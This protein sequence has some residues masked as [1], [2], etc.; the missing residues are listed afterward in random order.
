MSKP[1]IVLLAVLLSE[2]LSSGAQTSATSIDSL[3]ALLRYSVADTSRVNLLLALSRAYVPESSESLSNPDTALVLVRQAY[4]LSR[5]LHYPKGQGSS[6]L[7]GARALQEKGE[8]VQSRKYARQAITI[9][10]QAHDLKRAAQAYQ[11]LGYGYSDLEEEL[12]QKIRYFE[13]SLALLQKAGAR[14]AQADALFE[15]GKFYSNQQ[16]YPRCLLYCQQ[17]LA[18]YHTVGNPKLYNIYHEI[19]S[20]YT[21]LGNY[22]AGLKYEHLAAKSA[23]QSQASS[24][25]LSEVYNGI[26]NIYFFLKEPEKA[27]SYYRKAVAWAQKYQMSPQYGKNDGNYV[28]FRAAS[29]VNILVTQGKAKKA[30]SFLTAIAQEYPAVTTRDQALLS[31][32]LLYLHTVLK[33]YAPARIEYNK[34]MAL[35]KQDVSYAN[36]PFVYKSIVSFLLATKQYTQARIYLKKEE[37]YYKSNK[38]AKAMADN[39]L[40][41]FKLDSAQANYPSAIAHYQEYTA[42]KDSLFTDTESKQ[43]ATLDVQYRTQQ[44]DQNIQLLSKEKLLQQNAL[45]QAQTTRNGMFIGSVM[46][47]ALLGLVL[48][49]YRI[50]QRSN[51][52]LEAKQIEIDEKNK[53]LEILLT[54]KEW[55]LQEIHHRV[56]N[57]LQIIISLLQSQS[58]YLLDEA[59]INA[60]VQ[61]QHRVQAMALIHQKLYRSENLT[62]IYMPTYIAEVVDHLSEFFDPDARVTFQFYLPPLDLDVA[63][64]VPL[65]LIINEAV[66]NALKYAFPATYPATCQQSTVKVSLVRENAGNYLLVVADNGVGMPSD[67]DLRQSKSMGA[68][69]MRGLSKQLGGALQVDSNEGVTISVPFK[70]RIHPRH[71]TAA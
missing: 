66:T 65:G 68:N 3:I 44:K 49:R 42:I 2:A 33:Q 60:I 58:Q 52:L 56:K 12:P 34:L 26:G 7:V 22:P 36:Q 59:A 41:W 50:K 43:I 35:I 27:L 16:D 63:Q 24:I 39:Q 38:I 46:L 71:A 30:L 32:F 48:N 13:Q 62:Q 8:F 17:A 45:R 19:G 1:R 40:R 31:P 53:S 21:F 70:T 11:A 29:I 67:V 6:F 20:T 28:L 14:Q 61:S 15:L 10:T 9:F 64:A 69:I 5:A 18:L 37:Q 4:A 57:N 25:E 54:E 51:R 55:L 23:E 47:L